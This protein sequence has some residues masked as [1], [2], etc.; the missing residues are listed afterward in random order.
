LVIRFLVSPV[1]IVGDAEGRVVGV[2]LV[3]NELVDAGGGRLRPR[4]TDC[5]EDLPV[6]LVFRSVG[7]LGVPLPGVPV[8]EKAGTL[9][10]AQGRV[11][12]PA[13]KQ[14]LA[15][16]YA[17]GWI[18]RGPSG[19][20]GTNKACSVETV[21]CMLEDVRAGR[22]LAPEAPGADAAEALVRERQPHYF[23]FADW[24]R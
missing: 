2:R 13:T 24:Q 5:F 1:E 8:D 19:V 18:K 22:L 10:H 17:G 11:L 20:I 12:D 23:T 21:G 9:L 16:V 4:A 6:G 3:R 14:P 7:Y 15:G